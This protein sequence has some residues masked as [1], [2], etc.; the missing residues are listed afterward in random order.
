MQT[1]KQMGPCRANVVNLP[2][3]LPVAKPPVAIAFDIWKG[4]LPVQPAAVVP[5]ARPA[6]A[7][8]VAPVA[9][10]ARSGAP[11]PA[12]PFPLPSLDGLP[13]AWL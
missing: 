7:P 2:A 3:A 6:P 8:G 13:D 5:A 10:S 12:F 4:G 1:I 9:A 11:A